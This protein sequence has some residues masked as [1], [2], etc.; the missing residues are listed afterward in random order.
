[1]VNGTT[2]VPLEDRTSNPFDVAVPP[3]VSTL[4]ANSCECVHGLLI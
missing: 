4:T 3:V 2:T 1:M